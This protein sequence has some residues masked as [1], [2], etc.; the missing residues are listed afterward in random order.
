MSKTPSFWVKH[1]KPKWASSPGGPPM[2]Y[3]RLLLLSSI[4]VL[5][6]GLSAS[7]QN[8][9]NVD[10]INKWFDDQKGKTYEI[11]K[12]GEIQKPKEQWQ[13]PGN[14]EIPKGWKAIKVVK[15]DCK[16]KLVLNADTLFEFDK[17]TLTRDAEVTLKL[18]GPKLLSM[19]RHPVF[20][21]GHTDGKGTDEYNQTLSE[22]RAERVKNW[23]L[24]NHFVCADAVVQGWGKRK[25]VAPNANPDGSDNPKGRQQNRRVEI[26]VDTCKTLPEASADKP[27]E[28]ATTDD[29]PA[30]PK[31]SFTIE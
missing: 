31:P 9:Q 14:I 7:A 11:Q 2:K 26:I 1:W 25:P 10:K 22:K 24:S 21:D 5:G 13:T 23:L 18:V 20:I 4:F 28:P 12:P 19:G 27:A 3:G 17:S 8:W 15:E 6:S 30:E 16:E 29:K